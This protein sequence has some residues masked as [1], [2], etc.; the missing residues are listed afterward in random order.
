M[1]TH[2]QKWWY[3]KCATVSDSFLWF[4][5][6]IKGRKGSMLLTWVN[7]SGI[8][9]VLFT[10]QKCSWI[11]WTLHGLLLFGRLSLI[12]SMAATKYTLLSLTIIV[13]MLHKVST[14]SELENTGLLQ[15]KMQGLILRNLFY[16]LLSNDDM[17]FFLVNCCFSPWQNEAHLIVTALSEKNVNM[18]PWKQDW[19]RRDE[20]L[21]RKWIT[22]CSK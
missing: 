15:E 14:N 18:C 5:S 19:L 4:W 8:L 9:V 22:H 2:T 21:R 11:I 1:Q 6:K 12:N 17:I 10:M 13:A 20:E 3:T 7:I 16:T